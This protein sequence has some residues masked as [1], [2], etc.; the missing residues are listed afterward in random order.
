MRILHLATSKHGGA[1]IAASRLNAALIAE[2]Y[3][4][5]LFTLEEITNRKSPSK[6]KHF[7]FRKLSTLLNQ[8][9]TRRGYIST[10]TF[11]ECSITIDDL[12][13]YSPDVV[14]IHNWYNFLSVEFIAEIVSKYPTAITMHDERLITGS[15]HYSLE[16]NGYLS[17]CSNCPA[18]RTFQRTVSMNKKLLQDKIKSSDNVIVIAPSQWLIN[19]FQNTTLMQKISRTIVIPNII[20]VPEIV[21]KIERIPAIETEFRLLFA[22]VNPE[23]PTKGLDLLIQAVT[24]FAALNPQVR[25][26]LDI[27]G[28][29]VVVNSHLRNLSFTVHGIQKSSSMDAF[30]KKVDLVVVPSRIDNSPSII[31]EAQ[32][33]G[34]LVLG[35]NVGGIPELITDS[36]SGLLCDPNVESLEAGLNR[37]FS[38][39][40][41]RELVDFAFMQAAKRHDRANII[42]EHIDAYT[43]LSRNAQ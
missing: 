26:N 11:S 37:A 14:H 21:P 25:V 16:C 34:V 27:V 7:V 22:A 3:D 43:R 40:K 41:K 17:S 1:G 29:E 24:N 18:V 4:S 36:I 42:R 39:V 10:S 9:N 5:S 30:F 15:C 31:S 13:N 28:K 2:G 6:M 20:Y 35:T 8:T 23:A 32:L 12:A 33:N 19:R 38:T